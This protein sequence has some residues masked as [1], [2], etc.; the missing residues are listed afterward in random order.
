MVWF[1]LI[2][3]ICIFLFSY[4]VIDSD[5]LS[6]ILLYQFFSIFSILTMLVF[7]VKWELNDY[8]IGTTLIYLSGTIFFTFGCSIA[9]YF[10][11]NNITK[12]AIIYNGYKEIE[13]IDIGFAKIVIANLVGLAGLYG[14]ISFLRK[15]AGSSNFI[16]GMARYRYLSGQGAL[17]GEN[18]KG[19]IWCLCSSFSIAFAYCCIFIVLNNIVNRKLKKKD[20][21]LVTPFLLKIAE[22]TILSSRGDVINMVVAAII[23][24]FIALK[25]KRG[26]RTKVNLKVVK[27]IFRVALIFVPFF[28][29]SLLLSG[30]YETL[31][32]FD[33][34]NSSVIYISGGI[35]NLDLFVKDPTVSS[36]V[37]GEETFSYLIKNLFV[38]LDN[39]RN[40][41]RILEFRSINGINI[42]NIYTAF[43]RFYHDFGVIGVFAFSMLQGW[44]ISTLYYNINRLKRSDKI[45]FIEIIYCFLSCTT[46][47]IVIEDTFYSYYASITG[48]KIFIIFFIVYFFMFGL[49]SSH[50]G[51]LSV[52]LGK[53]RLH[54]N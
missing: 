29:G 16:F 23:S 32:G 33:F 10:S 34:I 35:R 20:L 25:Y 21:L 42:G 19:R 41:T 15:L 3:I 39:G 1:L 43:R 5:L 53:F 8:G 2:S 40:I 54:N 11:R 14:T 18:A 28:F 52:D 37:F 48:F 13:R 9:K 45:G 7:Y 46:I 26:W 12:R 24:W 36:G 49:R 27:T 6:P 4:Y 17:I 47:Y 38:G 31:K 50:I 51:V 30:R 44:I 22:Y